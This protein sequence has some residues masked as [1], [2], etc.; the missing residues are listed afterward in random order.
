MVTT[1]PLEPVTVPSLRAR[2]GSSQK[3]SAL[4]AY[5]YTF[6]SLIDGA[7]IEVVLVGDSLGSVIQ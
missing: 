7:G 4:T 3:I 2:K 1:L 6:A 5:D